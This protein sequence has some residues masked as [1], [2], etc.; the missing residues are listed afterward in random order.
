MEIFV[1]GN[2]A[3]RPS[4][5][6]MISDTLLRQLMALS[7]FVA[8]RDSLVF[9]IHPEVVPYLLAYLKKDN[10]VYT[11]SSVVVT[12]SGYSIYVSKEIPERTLAFCEVELYA[13]EMVIVQS[14]SC[15]V[16]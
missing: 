6:R 16:M 4:T 12:Y 7:D 11:G 9:V 3:L 14:L 5:T 2:H 8:D 10:H 1:S 13:E 15:K